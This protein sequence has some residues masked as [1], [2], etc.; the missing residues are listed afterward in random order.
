MVWPTAF[1]SPNCGRSRSPARRLCIPDHRLASFGWMA[2]PLLR[3]DRRGSRAVRESRPK[4]DPRCRREVC[5]L[6]PAAF[7]HGSLYPRP[8]RWHDPATS[9]R[10]PR[11][12]EA[13]GSPGRGGSQVPVLLGHRATCSV[14]SSGPGTWTGA[15]NGLTWS[16]R[17]SYRSPTRRRLPVREQQ[18][19][20]PTALDHIPRLAG[21]GP[22]VLVA[23][24]RPKP[25][26]CRPSRRTTRS[27]LAPAGTLGHVR[28]S[29]QLYLSSP[30]NWLRAK[31]V[32]AQFWDRPQRR[33]TSMEAKSL[34]R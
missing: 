10:C 29:W 34:Y 1:V 22:Y 27:N 28:P 21:P 8:S 15:A 30:V 5:A 17:D 31:G 16:P 3:R 13:V 19:N 6:V 14:P 23:R 25:P 20:G 24:L 9:R 4:A 26:E 11:R 32:E 12:T 7:R 33:F 2:V 18:V